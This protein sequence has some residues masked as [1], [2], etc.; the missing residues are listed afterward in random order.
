KRQMRSYA[1]RNAMDIEGLGP[2]IIDQLV[3]TGLVRAIPDLYRL[4]EEPLVELERM[5]KQSAQNL[6]EGIAASKGRGLSR[7]LTGLAIPDVGEGVADLLAQE[8]L[9]IDDLM[10]APA[11]RLGAVKGIGPS[12]VESISTFFATTKGRKTVEDL[13]SAGVKLTEEP[14]AKPT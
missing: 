3:D 13:R 4:T 12:R 5:G 7:V 6:L 1:Q 14:R 2:E 8:F 11:D 9:T 10:N